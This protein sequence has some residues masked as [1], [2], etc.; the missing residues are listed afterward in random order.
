MQFLDDEGQITI[1]TNQMIQAAQATTRPVIFVCANPH[2]FKQMKTK[3]T[4]LPYARLLPYTDSDKWS[5]YRD[6]LVSLHNTVM[7]GLSTLA[8]SST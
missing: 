5:H 7:A 8:S 3:V 1:R 4:I 2:V 6:K